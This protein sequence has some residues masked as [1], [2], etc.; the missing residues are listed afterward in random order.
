[1]PL[2][3]FEGSPCFCCVAM[4]A[5]QRGQ[6]EVNFAI[7]PIVGFRSA[8]AVPRSVDGEKVPIV[9]VSSRSKMRPASH[10]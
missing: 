10:L 9:G 6:L 3:R 4:G 7:A 5:R 8:S 1:M 2:A